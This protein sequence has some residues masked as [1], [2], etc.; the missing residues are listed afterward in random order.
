MFVTV[1]S[2]K[3]TKAQKLSDGRVYYVSRLLEDLGELTVVVNSNLNIDSEVMGGSTTSQV[4]VTNE[5]QLHEL[6]S[7]I[8]EY[9]CRDYLQTYYLNSATVDKLSD[10]LHD[11]L[12]ECIAKQEDCDRIVLFDTYSFIGE[13]LD[14]KW[15]PINDD[16][17][18]HPD[19]HVVGTVFI[20]SFS[21][22]RNTYRESVLDSIKCT[23]TEMVWELREGGCST[24]EDYFVE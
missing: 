5:S 7:V 4:I 10:C 21:F 9:H 14:V 15:E 17:L 19:A 8:V 20:N 2:D 18:D 11:S 13:L 24:P 16:I 22:L 23:F 3:H 1:D 12:S 6:L